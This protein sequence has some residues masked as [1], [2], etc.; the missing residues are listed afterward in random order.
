MKQSKEREKYISQLRPLDNRLKQLSCDLT[1]LLNEYLG[2]KPT[3]ASKP[4]QRPALVR[5]DLISEVRC[6][7]NSYEGPM[8]AKQVW[9]HLP[10]GSPG[11][12]AVNAA[13]CALR[14]L[15]E[16]VGGP[17]GWC[18]TQVKVKAG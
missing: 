2:D 13:C 5:D 16:L 18:L 10:E 12:R 9:Q 1:A 8:R 15:G 4:K 3:P 17:G 11:I 6:V 7:F 14:D